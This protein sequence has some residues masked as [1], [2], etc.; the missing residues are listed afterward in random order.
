ML[1]L[2]LTEREIMAIHIKDVIKLLECVG[3]AR[4]IL[5]NLNGDSV[6]DTVKIRQL[7]IKID[8]L[9]EDLDEK[10]WKA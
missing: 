7:I 1:S 6:V 10:G 2:Y 3:E 9:M 8:R 5:T 4:K